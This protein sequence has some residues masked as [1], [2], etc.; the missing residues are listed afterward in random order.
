MTSPTP[1]T[2]AALRPSYRKEWRIAFLL[3]AALV[4]VLHLR[5]DR[6][7]HLQPVSPHPA[8]ASD[9]ADYYLVV[10]CPELPSEAEASRDGT[11]RLMAWMRALLDAGFHPRPFVDVIAS[12]SRGTPLPERTVV[13]VFDPAYRATVEQVLPRL[14][15]IRVPALW[16]T[17]S[18]GVLRSDRRFVSNRARRTWSGYALWD[19]AL[20]EDPAAFQL[21]AD[22]LPEDVPSAYSWADPSG[23]T[24]I[25]SLSLGTPLHRLHANARWSAAEFVDRL[26]ADL[27]LRRPSP[28]SARRIQGRD[29]G[30]QADPH[31]V[32]AFRLAAPPEA[33]QATVRWLGTRGIGDLKLSLRAHA[34]CG[35]LAL[36]LRANSALS[37]RIHVSLTEDSLRVQQELQ[38][39]LVADQRLAATPNPGG[40]TRLQLHLRDDE[41]RVSIAGHAASCSVPIVVPATDEGTVAL[42]V[43]HRIHGVA[44][45]DQILLTAEPLPPPAD[46]GR[47]VAHRRNGPRLPSPGSITP[48]LPPLPVSLS[49]TLTDGVA[50]TSRGE[51]K[52]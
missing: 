48:R 34:W 28:L 49:P 19:F 50:N 44:F 2:P 15:E 4:L 1:A 33:R 22:G 23:L 41:L 7:R 10:R 42:S 35:E 52:G 24:G 12:L 32:A 3:L 25:N 21:E 5:P 13:L 30:I 18:P 51:G 26:K 36:D 20:S 17:R 11:R 40:S 9:R 45:A 14:Q 38:G 6:S 8:A 29:W 39:R 31:E 46:S 27:P 37:N 43:Y 47:A 16:I